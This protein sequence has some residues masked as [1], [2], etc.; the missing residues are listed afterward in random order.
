MSY[1]NY[2]VGGDIGNWLGNWVQNWLGFAN[3]GELPPRPE[4]VTNQMLSELKKDIKAEMKTGE[5]PVDTPA[6]ARG[7]MARA[8]GGKIYPGKSVGGD[9]GRWVGNWVQNW[10]GFARGGSVRR[11]ESGGSL[12]EMNGKPFGKGERWQR[13]KSVFE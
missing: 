12:E 2:S 10:L 3:G 13:I 11:F 1:K 5:F 4:G 8:R 6:K 9:I 7:G